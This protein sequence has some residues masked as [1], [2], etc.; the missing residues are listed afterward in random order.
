L[1]YQLDDSLDRGLLSGLHMNRILWLFAL[2]VACRTGPLSEQS[3]YCSNYKDEASCNLDPACNAALCSNCGGAA[4]FT[5]CLPVG[6]DSH[7]VCQALPCAPVIC[8]DAGSA[9]DCNARPNCHAV[10]EPLMACGCPTPG[11]CTR[12][13]RCTDGHANCAGPAVCAQTPPDCQGPYV[14]A[15]TNSCFE[16]CVLQSECH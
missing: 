11:C 6:A 2:L 15:Y 14:V 13:A 16:G 3:V 10:F 12:Y 5:A 4:V 9:A 1:I 8:A 7:Q